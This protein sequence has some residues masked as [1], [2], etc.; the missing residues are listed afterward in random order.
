MKKLFSRYFP[1][2]WGVFCCCACG[3]GGSDRPSGPSVPAADTL[4]LIARQVEH[5]AR[6]YTTE[7]RIHKIVTQ[8]DEPRLQGSILGQE[9]DWK[10]PAAERH[11][12][13]PI[14]VTVKAY[15]DF[16]G[17]SRQ[18]VRRDGTRLVVT[19]PDPV[20]VVTAAKID[21]KALRQYTDLFGTRYSDDEM[22]ALA[23][24][25][26]DSIRANIDR[27]DIL[28]TARQ[29][30][31]QTLLPM[32]RRMGFS[33]NDVTLEFRSDLRPTDLKLTMKE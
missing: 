18:Q 8:S 17:F 30:G 7:Y 1:V 31:A 14:D 4:Q 2:L 10:L 16:A 13:L 15:I 20:I 21:N 25:G 29:S 33:E 24:Q 27:A 9:V 19:L 28:K 22:L 23:R 5:V 32:L 11:I 6:L 3:N 12:A 26:E